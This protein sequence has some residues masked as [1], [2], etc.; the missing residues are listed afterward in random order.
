MNAN[1]EIP[2]EANAESFL[3]YGDDN[4]DGTNTT[5]RFIKRRATACNNNEQKGTSFG[6]EK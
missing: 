2:V 3:S 6:L 4:A 1:E 5:F